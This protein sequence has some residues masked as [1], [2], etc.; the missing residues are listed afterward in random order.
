MTRAALYFL[1]EMVICGPL[2]FGNVMN[3]EEPFSA[4]I[5]ARSE[6]SSAEDCFVQ[7]IVIIFFLNRLQ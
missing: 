1:F 2:V 7:R 3:M 4:S 5:D 6:S